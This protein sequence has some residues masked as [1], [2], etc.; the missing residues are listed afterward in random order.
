M[1]STMYITE[2]DQL[3]WAYDTSAA[4]YAALPKTPVHGSIRN[5]LFF[6]M[7]AEARSASLIP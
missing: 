6:D 1:A 7:H 3:N 2:C 4:W 5:T